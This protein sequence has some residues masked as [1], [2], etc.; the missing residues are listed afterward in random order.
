M[1]HS[2][3]RLSIPGDGRR[4]LLTVA[5]VAT[6]ALWITP[7]ALRAQTDS[8]PKAESILDQHIEATGG[9]AAYEN[10][11]N[12]VSQSRLEHVGMGIEDRVVVYEAAPAKRF[13]IAES[14]VLGV[15]RNGTNGDVV[16]YLCDQTGP[17]VET[18]EP[19]ASGQDTMAFDLLLNWRNYYKQ[20]ECKGI[21]TINGRECYKIEMIP[22]HGKTQTRFFDKQNHLLVRAIFTRLSNYM[23]PLV[24]EIS[25][26]DYKAVDGVLMTHRTTQRY[27]MCGNLREMRII[28]E[29]VQHNVDL[30]ANRFDPPTEI[31]ELAKKIAEGKVEV[32]KEPR[33]CVEPGAQ[34]PAG[35]N[36]QP[37]CKPTSE[38]E[39]NPDKPDKP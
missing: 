36:P 12:R 39:T 1:T 3:S 22:N 5:L 26:D 19:R 30:P 37:G 27:R 9:R 29:S 38:P 25:Y 35:C 24:M 7:G 11:R 18:G 17:Q 16:W 32:P 34:Q 33:G 21:E 31:Q 15:T 2:H 4:S 8:L 14:E 13:F 28:V 6:F 23:Q 10:I 20:V